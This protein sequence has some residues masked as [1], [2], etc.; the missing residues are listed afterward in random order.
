[1]IKVED[2]TTSV[3]GAN[4]FINLADETIEYLYDANGNMVKDLNKNIDS[5]YYNH[6]NLPTMVEIPGGQNSVVW[7][8]DAAGI[9]LQ[10]IKNEGI[11]DTRTDYVGSFIYE[12]DELQFI[13]TD[14]GKIMVAKDSLFQRHY[15]I[16]DHLGNTRVTFTDSGMVIQDDSYYPF[17]M[18]MSGLSYYNSNLEED[19]KNN[20][21][22]N[23]KE[24]QEDFDLDWYDYGARFYDAQLGRFHTVDPKA[25]KFVYQSL[26]VY[27]GNDPIRNI[28]VN[29]EYKYPTGYTTED[30]KKHD[31]KTYRA[32]YKRLTTF[33]EGGGINSVLDNPRIRKSLNKYTHGYLTDS[34]IDQYKEFGNDNSP[35]IEIRSD[36]GEGINGGAEPGKIQIDEKIVL[37]LENASE[38]DFEAALLLVVAKILH[39]TMEEAGGNL[40]TFVPIEGEDGEED[41]KTVISVHSGILLEQ[42]IFGEHVFDINDAQNVVDKN[43]KNNSWLK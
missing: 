25:E 12:N 32:N 36:L 16:T 22:Y 19:Q 18:T 34:K 23:G 27:A 30:G 21:L 9:K 2:D 29:G 40:I 15:N 43:K 4:G 7:T 6:L 39:E 8:Y 42:E 33:L 13:L 10:K 14:Y 28:D 24:L 17:G 11:N 26:Y 31:E 37:G 5:V 38:E 3:H 35:T 41:E 1:L 20:Y